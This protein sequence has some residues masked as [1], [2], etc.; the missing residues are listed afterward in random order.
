MKQGIKRSGVV[1]LLLVLC[2]GGGNAQEVVGRVLSRTA[3][4]NGANVS[5]Y[6]SSA[7]LWAST[8]VLNERFLTGLSHTSARAVFGVNEGTRRVL[9]ATMAGHFQPV[10]EVPGLTSG[11]KIELSVDKQL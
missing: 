9:S 1:L 8:Y 3:R 4:V 10:S 7:G 11:L 6:S 2:I 5:K